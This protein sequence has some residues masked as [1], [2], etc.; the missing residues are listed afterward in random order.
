MELLLVGSIFVSGWTE[1]QVKLLFSFWSA[2]PGAGFAG[3]APHMGQIWENCSRY[4]RP[5]KR[6]GVSRK[7]STT[8]RPL[9]GAR[10]APWHFSGGTGDVPEIHRKSWPVPPAPIVEPN[11]QWGGGCRMRSSPQAVPR[12]A[13][14]A[15]PLP[16][17]CRATAV[18]QSVPRPSPGP[19][20][21]KQINLSFIFLVCGAAAQRQFFFDFRRRRRRF[22]LGV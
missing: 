1:L 6:M 7:T 3:F 5:A 2:L 17:H 12:P 4:V 8:Q 14:E 11:F 21:Q 19:S 15:A 22:F 13:A 20:K 16:C 10:S 9:I 18:P